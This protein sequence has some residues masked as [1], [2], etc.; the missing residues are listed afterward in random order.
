MAGSPGTED[1]NAAGNSDFSRKAL[2]LAEG[3]RA[4]W[5]APCAQDDNKTPEAHLAMKAR[6]KGGPRNSITSLQVLV[7]EWATP[8][9]RDHFPP[10]TPERIAA[11]KAEGH[12]MRNLN[13]EAATW[14]GPSDIS[15]RGGSQP[16]EKR[17]AGGHSVNLEDQAEHWMGPNVPNGGRT[18]HHAEITGRTAMHEG[19]KVQV[20]LEHQAQTWPAPACRDHKGSSAS[21]IIRQDGKSRADMLDFAAEQ[22]FHPP[23]SPDPAIAGGAMSSTDGPNSNQPSTK[24]KLNPIFVEALMRWPTGLSGFER[25]ETGLILWQQ[26]MLGFLSGLCSREAPKQADLF[27]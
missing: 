1:Y 8:Q 7:Q 22:F 16:M 17:Q 24:R 19:K 9:A 14:R 11:K 15:K 3:M 27:G 18:A 5:P 2:E 4:M 12:G 13:D 26:R 10:H 20:G 21:S 6:M 23:S 25:Q